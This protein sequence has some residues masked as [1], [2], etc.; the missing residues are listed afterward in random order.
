MFDL[1]IDALPWLLPV[2]VSAIVVLINIVS[3]RPALAKSIAETQ[4]TL[5]TMKSEEIETLKSQMESCREEIERLKKKLNKLQLVHVT[6]VR[7]LEPLGIKITID[8]EFVRIT[9]I[10]VPKSTIVSIQADKQEGR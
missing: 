10:E 2:V 6:L 7:A 4:A 9:E 1:L 3:F 5:L 8:E